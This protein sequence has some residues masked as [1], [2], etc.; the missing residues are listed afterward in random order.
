MTF[1]SSRSQLILV[2]WFVFF[3]TM[4][5]SVSRDGGVL[6]VMLPAVELH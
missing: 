5:A 6:G 3:E 1:D 4:T 2:F